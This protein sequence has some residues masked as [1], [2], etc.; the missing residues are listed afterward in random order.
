MKVAVI[1]EWLLNVAGS[2]RVL[3]E[4]MKVYPEA[5]IYTSVFDS[6]KAAPFTKFDVRTSFLQKV[7]LAKSKRE[8]LIPLTPLAFEQF[9][10]SEYDLVLSNSHMAAKGVLTKP[11]TIHISYCHTP[12]R[13]LWEP[14]VD[15]RAKGGRFSW[16]KNKT[17]HDMRI[18]DRV[19]ADRVDYF[20]GNSKYISKRIKK[21]YRRESDFLYPPVDVERFEVAPEKEIKDYF[22]FV[23][24]L[25]S[26]KKCDLV[27]ESFN[28]LGLPL[29]IIG[30]GSEEKRLKK[31]AKSNI[32]FLGHVSDKEQ[33]KYYR[34]AKAFIFPA[35]E[36]FGIVPVEAM[37][38]GRPVIA[39]G[40]GGAAETV[41]PGKTGV[42]FP[43]QTAESL[44]E[45]IKNFNHRIYNS[46]EI[47]GWAEKF[48]GE[49]FRAELKNKI[50]KILIKEGKL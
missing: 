39:Y 9:D 4:I 5:V 25:I 33:A 12:P 48:S 7:P 37:A 10:L 42:L 50:N 23:S 49:R 47:R 26:Y 30:Q 20:W 36:D 14:D 35:E 22:L 41:I 11:K 1:H 45:T 29:K 46:K 16:L 18:W 3:L 19:A 32:E 40:A 13:Y 6:K 38:C 43:E 31:M 2:E 21:Y 17:A 28:K 44:T 27:V 8:I 34:E 24:R 15:P